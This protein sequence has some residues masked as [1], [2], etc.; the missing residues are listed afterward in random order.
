MISTKTLFKNIF[1]QLKGDFEKYLI[2]FLYGRIDVKR[3]LLLQRKFT[4]IHIIITTIT[5]ICYH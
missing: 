3:L 4:K 1:Q 5:L 2:I